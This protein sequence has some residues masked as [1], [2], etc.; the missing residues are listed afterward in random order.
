[1]IFYS[2]LLLLNNFFRLTKSQDCNWRQ[3]SWAPKAKNT[4]RALF[5][6]SLLLLF[7]LLLPLHLLLHLFSPKDIL[8]FLLFASF[9]FHI[10]VLRRGFHLCI[11]LETFTWKTRFC[12][13][14]V[15]STRLVP[16]F[17]RKS[18]NGKFS[19]KTFLLQKPTLVKINKIRGSLSILL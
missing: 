5:P 17:I 13:K 8:C 14:N 7:L 18:C 1:M 6:S 2:I 10:H 19:Y 12:L 9:F 11:W 16:T 3:L 15:L 4:H